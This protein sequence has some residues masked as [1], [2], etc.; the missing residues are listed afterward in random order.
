MCY[1]SALVFSQWSFG[2][3]T[4][5]F[6]TV[7]LFQAHVTCMRC[8]CTLLN[9]LSRHIVTSTVF[10]C[11]LI[12]HLFRDCTVYLQLYCIIVRIFT[13][14]MFNELP[15][16]LISFTCHYL[17]LCTKLITHMSKPKNGHYIPTHIP[18]ILSLQDNINT[19]NHLLIFQYKLIKQW[20]SKMKSTCNFQTKQLLSN[21]RMSDATFQHYSCCLK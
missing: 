1:K 5:Q 13:F 4:I 17:K 12:G 20:L 7:Q 21:F 16:V 6:Q 15:V 11:R 18:L 2:Y 14:F 10:F 8:L 3:L 19:P 9:H